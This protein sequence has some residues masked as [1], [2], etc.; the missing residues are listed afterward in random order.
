VKKDSFKKS[1]QIT[2]CLLIG[3]LFLS[4]PVFAESLP[5][6]KEKIT[7]SGL[8]EVETNYEE[9]DAG[10]TSDIALATVEL[11]L[12]ADISEHVGGHLLLL[13]EDGDN[14][15][16]VDEGF[17]VLDGRDITSFY[18]NAGKMYIPFGNFESHFI[19]DPLTLEIG[20]TNE[21]AVKIGYTGK[22]AEIC[23]ALYNGDIDQ[24]G[25]DNHIDDFTASA[26]LTP[27]VSEKFNLILGLSY[28]SNIGESDG[29]EGEI[30]TPPGTIVNDVPGIGLSL[31][32]AFLEKYFV[33][34]EYI[35]AT[36]SFQAGELNFDNGQAFKPDAFNFEF[37]FMAADNLELALRYESGS[38]LGD[39]FLPEERYGV[40]AS[41]ALYD[42]TTLSFEYLHSLFENDDDSGT[43]TAQLSIAF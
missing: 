1:F 34:L 21:H 23:L 28:I 6:W 35:S 27:D 9:A 37:A 15:V 17:I 30:A 19:S 31:N 20:E 16:N 25:D 14:A 36:D 38:D 43:M 2:W 5:D 40:A 41:S 10:D 7:L 8:I 39:D 42:N 24:T 29:L 22:S 12:D 4:L 11:G 32:L 26:L 3:V 13:W 33:E 18:L